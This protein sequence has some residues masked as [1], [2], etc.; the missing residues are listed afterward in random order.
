MASPICVYGN[1]VLRKKSEPVKEVTAEIR[2]LADRM[3]GVMYAQDGI[4]LAA[5]T[6]RS[7]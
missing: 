1:P 3:L 2:A 4:G 6:D 7:D 5:G